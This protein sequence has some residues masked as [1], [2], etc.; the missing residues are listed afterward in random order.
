MIYY[1]YYN[2]YMMSHTLV[3]SFTSPEQ[4]SSSCSHASED[5]TGLLKQ[6]KNP[7]NI[8]TNVVAHPS[9]VEGPLL[10]PQG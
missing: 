9:V 3:P 5:L 10:S 2:I 7:K 1:M 6:A 8:D 4:N